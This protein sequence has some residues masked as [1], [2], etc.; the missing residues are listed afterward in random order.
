MFKQFLE[1]L[2]GAIGMIVLLAICWG[3]LVLTGVLWPPGTP[4]TPYP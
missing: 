2:S 4:G 1:I 3:L